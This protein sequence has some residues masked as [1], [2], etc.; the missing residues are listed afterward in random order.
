[1]DAPRGPVVAWIVDTG[2]PNK[3]RHSVGAARQSCGQLGKQDHCQV[4]V[5][6]SVATGEASLPAGWRLSLPEEQAR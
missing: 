6:L 2:S 5:S 4:A 3:G 1:M